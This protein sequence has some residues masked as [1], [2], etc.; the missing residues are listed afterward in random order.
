M[1]RDEAIKKLVDIGMKKFEPITETPFYDPKA[2]DKEP[3]VFIE[4]EKKVY[5]AQVAEN[6]MLRDALKVIQDHNSKR[7][8]GFIKDLVLFEDYSELRFL[9]RKA[10]E[11]DK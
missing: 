7:S 9:A 8:S 11:G 1:T 6:K 2:G 5:D 4:V 3:Y 10:L